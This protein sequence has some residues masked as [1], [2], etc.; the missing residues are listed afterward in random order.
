LQIERRDA[1]VVPVDVREHPGVQHGYCSTEY[2]EQGSTRYAELQLVTEHVN[3]RSLTVGMTRH[4][5][6]YGMYYSREAVGSYDELVGLGQRT[7]SKEL[8]SDY[9]VL[10]Q[11]VSQREAGRDREIRELS[12]TAMRWEL[13]PIAQ[14][15]ETE[16]SRDERK[17]AFSLLNALERLER[18]TPNHRLTVHGD[19]HQTLQSSGELKAQI[20]QARERA[21]EQERA[22]T[23]ER[24]QK[25]E[26]ERNRDRG[27]GMGR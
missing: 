21:N 27:R 13:E 12:V 18:D 6:E 24:E 11:A 14:G 8:A 2:R 10:E 4:T 3:Q 23:I 17:A 15:I 22:P 25:L 7:K 5:H 26:H 9:R 16:Y 19:W 20:A 1:V